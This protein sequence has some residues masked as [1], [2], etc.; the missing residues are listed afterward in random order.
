M[1]EVSTSPLEASEKKQTDNIKKE[2]AKKEKLKIQEIEENESIWDSK[3]DEINAVDIQI[4][5]KISGKVF[6]QCIKTNMPIVFGN[7]EVHLKR[8]FKNNIDDTKEISAF[9]EIY[10]GQKK[11]FAKWLF[12]SS[13]SINVFSHPVY[14][15]RIDFPKP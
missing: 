8:C 12:A 13:P 11:I 10:E 14:D 5:D 7:I 3:P 9:I 15:V 1:T 6:N 4:L 2:D